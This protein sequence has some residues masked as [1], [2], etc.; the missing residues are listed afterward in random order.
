MI[1]KQ[2]SGVVLKI[3]QGDFSKPPNSIQRFDDCL[4]GW[5]YVKKILLQTSKNLLKINYRPRL[6]STL[7]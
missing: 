2:P 7:A 4:M 6:K 3:E 1:L 5:N